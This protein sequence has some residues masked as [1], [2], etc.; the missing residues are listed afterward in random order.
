MI[1]MHCH[2][3]WNVDDGPKTIEATVNMLEQAVKEGITTLIATPHSNHPQYDVNYETVINQ[4]G[5]LQNELQNQSIPLKLYSGHEVRLSEKNHGT[6]SH[7]T[8]PHISKLTLST[9]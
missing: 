6:L 2:L 1:D 5:L 7:Q 3:L 4:I 8:N 9:T